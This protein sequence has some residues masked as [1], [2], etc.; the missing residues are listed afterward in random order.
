MVCIASRRAIRFSGLGGRA[1]GTHGHLLLAVLEEQHCKR[2]CHVLLLRVVVYDTS[3]SHDATGTEAVFKARAGLS[4]G[5]VR[6]GN[7]PC[8]KTLSTTSS[9]HNPNQS[10]Y[11]LAIPPKLFSIPITAHQ[12]RCNTRKRCYEAFC[13]A[14]MWC[15]ALLW[16]R[17]ARKSRHHRPQAPT[18]RAY[19]NEHCL[20][21]TRKGKTWL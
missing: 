14:C 10:G 4:L 6:H 9:T 1:S 20:N 17:P 5:K 18:Q 19:C 11:Q 7:P 8:Q 13:A 12:V 15:L 16:H 21:Y 3:E 2:H